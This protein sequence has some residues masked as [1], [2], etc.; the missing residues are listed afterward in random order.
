MAVNFPKVW[1]ASILHLKFFTQ[2]LLSCFLPEVCICMGPVVNAVNLVVVCKNVQLK[3]TT[4][5]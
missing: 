1:K 3:K 2:F 5:K 4:E